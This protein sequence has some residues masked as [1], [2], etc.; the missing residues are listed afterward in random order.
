MKDNFDMGIDVRSLINVPAIIT[1][2][3]DGKIYPD[4]RPTDRADKVDIVINT[5][6]INNNQFQKGTANINVYAPCLTDGRPNYEKLTMISKAILPL[7]DVQWKLSFRT[8]VTDP[9]TLLRDADGNWFLSM[10]LSYESYNKQFNN[11]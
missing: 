5:L 1:L 4:V 7:V 2:L 10:Q 8:E 6:G 11:Y 3:G 9:G